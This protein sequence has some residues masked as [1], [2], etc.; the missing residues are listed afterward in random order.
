MKEKNNKISILTE[1][2]NKKQLTI[3]N[4]LTKEYESLRETQN[5]SNNKFKH[6]TMLKDDIDINDMN[7]EYIDME[8]GNKFNTNDYEEYNELLNKYEN[9]SNDLED[10]TRL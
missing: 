8:I 9:I 4:L 3:A 7:I 6:G 2:N 5:N 10:K 1:D